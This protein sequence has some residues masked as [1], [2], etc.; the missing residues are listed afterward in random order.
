MMS[1]FKKVCILVVAV[2]GLTSCNFLDGLVPRWDFEVQDV[3]IP[4]VLPQEK[5]IVKVPYLFI[6]TK[7]LSAQR[8]CARYRAFIDE[9]VY[10]SGIID[11]SRNP[12][13]TCYI[14]VVVPYNDSYDTRDVRI[15]VSITEGYDNM[16]F[17]YIKDQNGEYSW[18]E[19]RTV[20]STHQAG[21]ES[22]QENKLE[23]ISSWKVTIG[24]YVIDLNDSP[25]A[26]SFKA[27]LAESDRRVDFHRDSFYDVV[28]RGFEFEVYAADK[29]FQT[30]ISQNVP[31]SPSVYR[32]QPAGSVFVISD[33]ELAISEKAQAIYGTPLGFI[34]TDDLAGLLQ[35]IRSGSVIMT[36]LR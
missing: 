18:G 30:D 8:N 23:G 31:L 15:D 9:E 11:M 2:V 26:K 16:P 35:V 29:N 5:N 4:E 36:V 20:A 1:R 6:Q 21:L 13:D 19:W 25:A 17:S 14:S 24:G 22:G 27:M 32:D 7:N 12:S 3:D 10:S 28:H 33:G 34:S